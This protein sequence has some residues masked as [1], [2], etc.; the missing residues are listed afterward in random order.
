MNKSHFIV[1]TRFGSYKQEHNNVCTSFDGPLMDPQGTKWLLLEQTN[2][3]VY[4]I[5]NK[6]SGE[7]LCSNRKQLVNNHLVNVFTT[8][9]QEKVDQK[10][11][12]CSW[13]LERTASYSGGM[14]YLIWNLEIGQ[15]LWVENEK[16]G[17]FRNTKRRVYLRDGK[18]KGKDFKWI[19]NFI[20]NLYE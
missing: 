2:K 5:Q 16:I 18:F 17:S 1:P 10:D 13:R 11:V 14:T 6:K 12:S 4:L 7:F 3:A 15:A 8:N 19:G 9:L 20:F